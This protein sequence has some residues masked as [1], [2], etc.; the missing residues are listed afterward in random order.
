MKAEAAQD[1]VEQD[2]TQEQ[3][4]QQE[5]QQQASTA[6]DELTSGG[7]DNPA[8]GAAAGNGEDSVSI[9]LPND[10]SVE[11]SGGAPQHCY[12]S[13]I[14]GLRAVAVAGVILFHYYPDAIPGGF[15]GVDVFFVI[16]G[17]LIS[18]II[19][20]SMERGSFTYADFYSKRVRRIFPTYLV[21]LIATLL[22]GCICLPPDDLLATA[23][24]AA[25][26]SVFSANIGLQWFIGADEL[27][28]VVQP[29][30]SASDIVEPEDE[31]ENNYFFQADMSAD[32][33]GGVGAETGMCMRPAG[34][35]LLHLWSLG[36]EEQFY[37]VWP[38]V[39]RC[40]LAA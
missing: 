39:L 4:Q 3:E 27:E 38:L 31:F 17:Y 16:S 35:P 37:F 8:A 2:Q 5:Q 7:V 15:V 26:S 13:D 18:G 28:V 10:A 9:E 30:A 11:T 19:S 6:D 14:D 33:V 34:N 25:W 1:V 40:A 23:Q 29:G 22:A 21:V 36:V 24:T 32:D 20:R 12:R